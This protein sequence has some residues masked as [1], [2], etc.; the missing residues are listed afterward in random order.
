[1]LFL[2]TY[3]SALTSSKLDSY[4]AD[5]FSGKV[6]ISHSSVRVS[7]QDS[8]NR[9]VHLHQHCPLILETLR[10]EK[11]FPGTQLHLLSSFNGVLFLFSQT[12][13]SFI[14]FIPD[15]QRFLQPRS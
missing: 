6:K 15:F 8:D 12:P 9:L 13:G 11:V 14:D 1:M 3:L 2:A 5:E 10:L 4:C 7:T